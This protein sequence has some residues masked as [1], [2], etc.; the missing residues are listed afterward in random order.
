MENQVQDIERIVKEGI[1]KEVTVEG[2]HFLF[3]KCEEI[4]PY[5]PTW[6]GIQVSE[7]SGLIDLI[8]S[9][10]AELSLPK[11]FIEVATP[12]RVIAFTYVDNEYSR[13]YPYIAESDNKSYTFGRWQTYEDFIIALRSQ[14]ADTEARNSLIELITSVKNVDDNEVSDNGISQIA[15]TRKGALVKTG[16]IKAI[17]KLTPYRTFMEVPQAPAEYLFRIR[18]SVNELSFA[19][20]AADGNAWEIEQKAII[21]SH[22]QS[23]LADE[24]KS[25]KVIVIA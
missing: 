6:A 15:S 20:F 19:L 25:G 5:K 2:R 22:L 3:G 14:F 1:G 17:Y 7:L 8:K 18:Q 23:C 16:E 10:Y 11:L 4:R 12:K 13:H 21:K 24:I 9:E